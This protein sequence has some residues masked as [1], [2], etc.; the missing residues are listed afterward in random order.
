MHQLFHDRSSDEIH[1]RNCRS[2]PC[3]DEQSIAGKEL[4]GVD[5]TLPA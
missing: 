4:Q 5:P 2:S 3:H 1:D